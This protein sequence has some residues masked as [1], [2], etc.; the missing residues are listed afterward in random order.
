MGAFSVFKDNAKKN[1]RETPTVEAHYTKLAR[2]TALVRYAC[3]IFVVL[4]AAYSFSFHSNEITM[5]N[6]RYMLKFIN[7]GDEVDAPKGSFVSFDGSEGSRGLLF[8]GDLAVLNDSGLTITGWDGEVILSSSFSYDHPKMT[9]NGNF[10][11]CYDVG[12]KD[13]KIFNSYQQI[14]GTPSFD[15]PISWLAASEHGEFA[16]VSSA[17]SY[18]S[19][20][21]V[22]DNEYR[23]RYS[24]K[25]ADTYVDFVDISKNGTQFITAAHYSKKGNLVTVVSKFVLGTEGAVFTQEF[26]GEMPLGIYYTDNG[27]CLMT[28][29]TLRSFNN[30]GDVVSE[31][32][33]TDSELLSGRIFGAR[34]LVTYRLEGLSGGTKAVVYNED[35]TEVLTK[36]FNGSLSDAYINGDLL[37]SVSPGELSVY[38]LSTGEEKIYTVPSSYSALIADGERMIL[39]SE[40]QAEYFESASFAEKEDTI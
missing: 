7:L 5:E 29:D 28:S 24:Q 1:K 21:Y 18:R 20:V 22:Y 6:F 38:N 34:M 30:D 40:N 32:N 16:V 36:T 10:L 27:F 13:L 2:R 3:M 35:G 31:I 17:K 25:F 15:Y 19:A 37:Y 26:E 23:I 14:G 4:F 39:F 8:K 11:F 9:Q 33:L 12:G